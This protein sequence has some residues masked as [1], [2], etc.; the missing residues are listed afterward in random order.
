MDILADKVC[1]LSVIVVSII[2]LM[3][4]V[5]WTLFSVVDNAF[6]VNIEANISIICGQYTAAFSTHICSELGWLTLR[7]S[8]SAQACLPC[9]R[10]V[11]TFVSEMLERLRKQKST[12]KRGSELL[13]DMIPTGKSVLQALPPSRTPSWNDGPHPML[14]SSAVMEVEANNPQAPELNAEAPGPQILEFEALEQILEM[15]SQRSVCELEG[16][17]DFITE[18]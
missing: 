16:Q 14:D 4:Q 15:Y 18:L 5:M 8:L 9:L 6:W 3:A 2:R 13:M 12:H 17:R 11:I 1:G 10:P 7:H